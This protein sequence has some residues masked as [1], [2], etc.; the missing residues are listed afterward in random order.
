[1]AQRLNSFVFKGFIVP[2]GYELV[3][4]GPKG[5]TVKQPGDYS[6]GSYTFQDVLNGVVDSWELRKLEDNLQTQYDPIQID[7]E[8]Y[9]IINAIQKAGGKPLFVGGVVR[10]KVYG[11]SSKDIDVEIYGLDAS[12]LT[13][14]LSN[15]GKVDTVGA[16]F[17][18]IKLTTPN[19][20]YDF[21]LPRRES[22]QGEGHRGFI[23]E[24]DHTMTPKEA[25][26]RRDFTFNALAMTPQGELLDFYEGVKNLKEGTLRH[27]SER[28]A[29]DPLRVLRGFQFAGRFNLKIDPATAQLASELRREFRT[30]AVERIWGEFYKW[31]TKSTKPSAGLTVLRETGWV[32]LFPQLNN[33]IGIPQ[34]PQWHPE[35]DVWHH[36]LHVTDAAVE[37]ANREGLEGKDRA[38][39]LLASL[40]HDFGKPAMTAVIEGR[41]RA[42]AHP[43]EGVV[44]TE[45]F[46]ESI[47]APRDII[48]RILPLVKEHM[49]HLN[50]IN[51]R[52]I[53][54]LA[55]RLVPANI[56]ML[57]LVIEADHSGRP[58]L[59]KGMPK[60]AQ[61]MVAMA[62]QLR[63]QEDK[64]AP[65]IGGKDLIQLAKAGEIPSEYSR[66]GPHFGQL[67]NTLFNAQIDGAFDT[68][69][70]GIDYLKSIFLDPETSD[71]YSTLNFLAALTREDKEK[72]VSSANEQGLTEA[73]IMKLPVEQ[74]KQM[75]E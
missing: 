51:P 27:T 42:P 31:A 61:Q 6:G 41:W 63:V 71:I 34:D 68:Y 20:D 54:R 65:L 32:E 48:E 72:L 60:A 10:D 37:I 59:P 69:E 38:V 16:S 57:S 3:I 12:T 25:A 9:G 50:D 58:P 14:V 74:I 4:N 11:A 13:Q 53:R 40:C 22:K 52:S 7:Q 62:H 17:G 21:T 30:L 5:Q 67:I 35:G 47:G 43:V 19:Q 8:L 18:V 46:L 29:E 23:V 44:P 55:L 66:G 36:T 73:Q 49:A 2:K 39:L 26:S 64:P 33:L 70:E 28:F 15:F 24:P 75:L 45:E 56:D 1:M